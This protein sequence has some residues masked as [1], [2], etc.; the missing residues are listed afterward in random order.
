MAEDMNSSHG[1]TLCLCVTPAA[2]QVGECT[3]ANTQP[4]TCCASEAFPCDEHA[5]EI[6][7]APPCASVPPN[8]EDCGQSTWLL[9]NI[10]GPLTNDGN[11]GEGNAD[12]VHL[13]I[14]LQLW[15]CGNAETLQATQQTSDSG[16]HV[17]LSS[18][19]VQFQSKHTKWKIKLA[20][21]QHELLRTKENHLMHVRTSVHKGEQR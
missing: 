14:E 8:S 9:A 3:S 15:V 2:P 17:D 7:C 11:F 5:A 18:G 10:R 19:Y 12:W 16:R 4:A 13:P 21:G 20:Q 6:T 1:Q